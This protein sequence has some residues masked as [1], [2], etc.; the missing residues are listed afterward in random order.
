LALTS[1]TIPLPNINE[2]ISYYLDVSFQAQQETS[3]VPE[4]SSLE[5][6]LLGAAGL[7]AAGYAAARRKRRNEDE[8]RSGYDLAA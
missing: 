6:G 8:R 7:T 4:S 2:G 5:L 3:L 1:G